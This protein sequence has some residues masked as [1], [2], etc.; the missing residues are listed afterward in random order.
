MWIAVVACIG[1]TAVSQSPP[2]GP[3]AMPEEIYQ[4]KRYDHL[5]TEPRHTNE[6]PR[7]LFQ[8]DLQAAYLP[9]TIGGYVDILVGSDSSTATED[10]DEVL[11]E[12]ATLVKERND[13]GLWVTAQL[14]TNSPDERRAKLVAVE[15]VVEQLRGMGIEH[16]PF[17]IWRPEEKRAETPIDVLEIRVLTPDNLPIT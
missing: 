17:R 13:I 2:S 12:I 14:E 8:Y 7:G 11:K 4:P 16:V 3:K 6:R 1:F 9:D 10:S 5:T 15:T